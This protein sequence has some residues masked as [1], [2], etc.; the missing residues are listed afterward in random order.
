M[1]L[2]V[3]L[4]TNHCTCKPQWCWFFFFSKILENYAL[5]HQIGNV[6]RVLSARNAG[7]S[8]AGRNNIQPCKMAS[9]QRL[10]LSFFCNL[11]VLN[12][13]KSSV[14]VCILYEWN[15]VNQENLKLKPLNRKFTL[16]QLGK[17]EI[18]TSNPFSCEPDPT[19]L[20]SSLLR[21]N[22][23]NIPPIG[24]VPN[25]FHKLQLFQC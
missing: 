18:L 5:M 1:S 14:I 2:L 7:D 24:E 4:N 12:K 10:M 22:V 25:R 15:A 16:S 23:I 8:R 9:C 20:Q 21:H 17:V 13:L 19:T 11:L 6:P 3:T